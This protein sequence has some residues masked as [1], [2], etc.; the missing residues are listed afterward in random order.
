MFLKIMTSRNSSYNNRNIY[1]GV[2]T[3]ITIGNNNKNESETSNK[4]CFM[5]FSIHNKHKGSRI[6]NEQ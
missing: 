5:D 3:P 6:R 2:I 1:I 4:N